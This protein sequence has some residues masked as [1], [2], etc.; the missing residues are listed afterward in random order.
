[1]SDHWATT[2]W[3]FEHRPR[4]ADGRFLPRTEG[5]V[6]RVVTGWLAYSCDGRWLRRF[7]C[8][9]AAKRWAVAPYGPFVEARPSRSYRGVSVHA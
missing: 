9:E 4:D 2:P 6:A 3:G 8:P 7:R 5:R 1:M